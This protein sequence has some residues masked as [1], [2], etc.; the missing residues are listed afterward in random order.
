MITV[1]RT[2]VAALLTVLGIVW[3]VPASAD[4]CE[5]PLP[6]QNAHFSGVVRYI[7]DGDSLCIGPEG[8]PTNGD[9]VGVRMDAGLNVVPNA[10]RPDRR[11]CYSARRDP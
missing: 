2:G 8:N 4:P 3:S 7:G 11:I 1:P 5:G 10:R 9:F 6:R